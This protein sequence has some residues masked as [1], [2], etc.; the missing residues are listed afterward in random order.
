MSYRWVFRDT[1]TSVTGTSDAF[2]TQSEAEDW[3]GA[4]WK[5]LLD[6]GNLAASLMSD[7]DELYTMK[8]TTD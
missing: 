4:E 2:E 5:R 3:I 6:E 1:P 8:L 7:S